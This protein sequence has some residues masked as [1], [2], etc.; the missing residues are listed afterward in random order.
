M[1]GS[2]KFVGGASEKIAVECGHIDQ[3]VRSVV[4]RVDVGQGSGALGEAD[5]F[6]H[7]I[8]GADCI[9]GVSDGDQFCVLVHLA[10]EILHVEGAVFVA[11]SSPAHG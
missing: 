5:D 11:K 10:G 7:R 3:A 9:R 4:N 1:C 8:D 6:F 2:K